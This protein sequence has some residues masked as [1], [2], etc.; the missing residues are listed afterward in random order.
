MVLLHIIGLLLLQMLLAVLLTFL[1][2]GELL[3]GLRLG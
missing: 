3:L 2:A 1:E